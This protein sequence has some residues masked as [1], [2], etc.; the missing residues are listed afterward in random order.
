MQNHFLLLTNSK[1]PKVP[2]PGNYEIE[3]IKKNY[4]MQD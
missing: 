4:T 2:S 1:I 3:F